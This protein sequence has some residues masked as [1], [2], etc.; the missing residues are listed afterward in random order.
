MSSFEIRNDEAVNRTIRMKQSLIDEISVLAEK[1]GV[2]FNNL[3]VQMCQF[4]L[5]NLPDKED[6]NKTDTV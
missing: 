6:N 3:V 2:S 4:A 5:L 1:H